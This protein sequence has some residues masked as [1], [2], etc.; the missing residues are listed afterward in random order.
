MTV[1]VSIPAI[2][3]SMMAGTALGA[4]GSGAT[5]PAAL[6]QPDHEEAMRMA[7]RSTLRNIVLAIADLTDNVNFSAGDI[8]E[9]ELCDELN[10]SPELVAG[11]I[12]DAVT[13]RVL[14]LFYADAM[15]RTSAACA[16][17]TGERVSALR[18]MLFA[19]LPAP[20]RIR[21]HR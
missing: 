4:I 5:H 16:G 8:V 1:T 21:P 14:Q 17:G 18:R 9:L 10:I 6:L 15:P 13:A 3:Q 12:E 7:A 11:A 20:G 19:A 2:V